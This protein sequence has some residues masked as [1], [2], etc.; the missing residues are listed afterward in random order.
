MSME[1]IRAR[2]IICGTKFSPA[3]D[4]AVDAAVEIARITHAQLLLIH[5]LDSHENRGE[6]RQK[7]ELLI[8]QRAQGISANWV[9][10]KGEPGH[11]LARTARHERADLIVVGEGHTSEALVP[12]GVPDVL[13]RI[14]PCPVISVAAGETPLEVINRMQGVVV[15]LDEHHCIVCGIAE[16]DLICE[17]CRN[18]IT[19]EAIDRRN[20]LEKLAAHG[21]SS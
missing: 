15:R 3:C 10:A 12:S 14:A 17:S 19:G 20:R 21:M 11:V 4:A 16:V 6:V 13:E 18:R 9:V 7:L 2:L 5:V 8:D 1:D